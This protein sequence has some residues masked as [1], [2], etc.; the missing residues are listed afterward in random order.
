MA[1]L[2]GIFAMA[3]SS[4]QM[5]RGQHVAISGMDVR[6]LKNLSCD[7]SRRFMKV[8]F[9]CFHWSEQIYRFYSIG[10]QRLVYSINVKQYN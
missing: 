5:G 3:R 1:T 6:T 2:N 8:I 4:R 10:V 7:W 9:L